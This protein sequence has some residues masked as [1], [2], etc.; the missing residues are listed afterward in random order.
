[1]HTT[2]LQSDAATHQ[3]TPFFSR[4]RRR[5]IV[6]ATLLVLLISIA[7]LPPLVNVNRF[8]KRIARN[9][10]SALGR[11]VYFDHVALTLFPLPGFT[12]DNVVIDEDPAFGYEPILRADQVQVTLRLSSLWRTHTEFS[13]I[14]FSSP[15]VNL[16]LLNGHWNIESLLLQASHLEAAPTA[17]RFAGPARRFPYIEATGARLNLKLGQE[18][19]PVSL[20][21]ADFALWLPEPHQ[22]H[23]R[24]EAQPT[25][26][27]SNPGDT[28]TLRAEGTLG[29]G[30]LDATSLADTPIALEG[31][32]RDAQLGSLSRLLLGR[33]PGLRGDLSFTFALH[34]TVG[35]NAIAANLKLVKARRA[36]FVPDHMLSLEAS[37][38]ATAQAT[39]H[40]FTDIACSWPPAGSSDPP[41]LALTA[42]LPDVTH[43]DSATAALTL[44]SL[45]GDTLFDWLS[46][47]TP[48]PPALLPGAGNLIGT[49]AW[50]PA[51][52]PT[53][54]PPP[55]FVSS[56]ALPPAPGLP[57]QKYTSAPGTL[58][59]SADPILTGVLRFTGGSLSLDPATNRSLPLGDVVLTSSLQPGAPPMPGTSPTRPGVA[60]MHPDAPMPP[61]APFMRSHRMGGVSTLSPTDTPTSFTLQ[62]LSLDLGGH[63]PATLTG[64]FDA[65]GST[66]HLIGSVLPATLRQFANA[67]PQ[68]GEGLA[69]LLDQLTASTAT[70]AAAPA[71]PTPIPAA[72]I[73]IDLTATRLWG[74]PQIWTQ[75]A[76]PPATHPR[77]RR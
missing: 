15:S 44:P 5:L 72:P 41:L 47:A 18:K 14:A 34:G 29:G 25:R 40:S 52:H 74:A 39:F 77:H 53:P 23:L 1:M 35:H 24:L 71:T 33:D 28:G 70:P 38:S 69:P 21:D 9:I 63:Q 6:L 20:T 16:V 19:S 62:P 17:Q 66:L 68:L 43:P 37:C 22:W 48:H 73:S 56:S 55:A 42:S 27:D 50:A 51:L 31:D 10:S 30:S 3:P 67:I 49:L 4:G 58:P 8:Q 46:I 32:W 61:G 60:P 57:Q 13:K 2:P 7:V 65:T 59:A 12:L 45:P 54:S 76:P 11:P 64:H 75:T 36:D 26:T